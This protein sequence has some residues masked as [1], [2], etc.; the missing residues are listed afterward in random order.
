MRI[1]AIPLGTLLLAV[2][3]GA[4]LLAILVTP[5]VAQVI[6]IRTVPISQS[7]Q[8]DLFPSHGMAMGGVSLAIDDSLHDPFLNPAKGGRLAASRF[9]GSPGVYNVSSGAGAGRSLPVGAW[10]RSGSWFGGAAVAVQQIDLSDNFGPGIPPPCA[11]CL[12]V[13]PGAVDLPASDRTLGNTYGYAMFGKALPH[14]GLSLA[15]SVSWAGLH[16]VDGVDLLYP[17]SARLRQRGHSLDLRVG[18]VKEWPGAR[19]LSAVLLHNR[20]AATHDVFYLDT[21]W[22]PGQQTFSQRPRLEQNLDHTN[23]WGAHIEYVQPLSAGW[24]I[25]GVVT[26]NLM[27]HPKIPNYEI[28]NIPRDPGNSEAF[29]LGIGIAKSEQSFTFALDAVYEP[30]WSYT[31]A[32]TPEPLVTAGGTTIPAGGRTIENRFRFSNARLKMG[33][34][35]DVPFDEATKAIVVR[36]GLAVHRIDYGLVQD[37]NVQLTSRRLNEDWVEW[38]PT[39][40]MSL[41]FPVWEVH[42]RGSV[43]NGTGRPGVQS[44]GGFEDVAAPQ[45]GGTILVAPS[46]PLTL[47]GVRVMTHQVSITFPF[48]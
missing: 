38:T 10:L 8:F 31:W 22:D 45:A 33:F 24:R 36:L 39:W 6:P 15:G 9:F 30:I 19:T 14:A 40:G 27:S 13:Q 47:A 48:R 28:Q 46:G 3:L 2:L 37:D 11:V 44:N 20:F 17:G 26:T 1:R 34:A 7:H 29:N 5:M 18:A 23:N 16:G 35:Q 41:R 42:Y 25:G 12:D 32:D 4:L 21:F 43:T